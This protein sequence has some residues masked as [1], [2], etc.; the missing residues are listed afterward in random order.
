ML[1]LRRQLPWLLLLAAGCASTGGNLDSAQV[2]REL[3]DRGLDPGS[4]VI[5]YEMTDEMREWAHRLVP[6]ETEPEKRLEVLLA[7]LLD[8]GKL[9]LQYEA[10]Y[11]ATAEEVFQTRK[12]NC[13]A[14]TSL[15]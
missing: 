15:F 1:I 12:A 13:L 3:R 2:A 11:T 4:V 10:R 9:R 7:G 6:H 14:F 8:P 5:P